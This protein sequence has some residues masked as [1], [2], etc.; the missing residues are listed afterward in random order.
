MT[1][2]S[3]ASIAQLRSTMAEY[4]EALIALDVVEDCEGDLEDAAMVLA[5]R[6]GLQPD[7]N[8]SN[9][10]EA[11]ARQCRGVV[12]QK[13]MQADLR[14]GTYGS[15]AAYL[16]DSGLIPSILVA[17]VLMYILGTGIE[18]FCD[19]GSEDDPVL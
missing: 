19:F 9:W 15:V 10:L 3:M 18:V 7:Q 12:C 11:I 13:S 17:P 8:N 1:Q 6:Y 2:V 4:P 14:L 5:I 16:A